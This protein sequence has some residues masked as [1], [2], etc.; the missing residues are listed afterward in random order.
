[1]SGL[2]YLNTDHGTRIAYHKTD[3]E[4][5]QDR[6]GIIWCGGFMSDMEGSKALALEDYAKRTGR[7]YVRFD[8]QGHGA[9]DG[10]FADGTIGLWQ[11]DAMAVLD[12]LTSGP[13]ILV[14]SSMGGWI[15]MLTLKK[16]ADR[17]AGFIGIAAAP[18]FT[19]RHWQ[20][21]TK[22]Q[23]Q[24]VLTE[25]RVLIPSDYGPDPYIFTKALFDDGANNLVM[26]RPL[27][28]D[29]P[30]RLIQGTADPDVPWQTALDIADN[31]TGDDVEVILIPDGDHRLSRDLDLKRLVRVV[32]SLFHG[33]K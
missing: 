20:D 21:L 30:V 31:I 33:D 2:S 5:T 1:M 25:G 23:Q 27:E 15:S 3:G 11:Q 17:I 16:R 8:Y 24:D 18:D 32:D 29:I 26:T 28:T 22:D 13:Q 19:L 12:Q 6:P 9:S 7:A 10:A 4:S 14:G